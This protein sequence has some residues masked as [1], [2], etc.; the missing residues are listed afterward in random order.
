MTE[1][2]GPIVLDLLARAPLNE[3]GPGHPNLPARALLADLTPERLVAPDALSDRPMAL[4]ALAGLWLRHDFFDESH[5]I[6]QNLETPEGSYWHGI[7]HRREPDYGN[8]R[9]W[10]R[11]VAAH[12]IHK[13]LNA[14]AKTLCEGAEPMTSFARGEHSSS[15]PWDAAKF[16]QLCER[17]RGAGGAADR[18]PD[19]VAGMG[20]AV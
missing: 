2:Y 17:S 10:M 12:P 19:P 5:T 20:V 13:P 11:R 8:A 6:S 18:S 4:A 9:Y 3:L 15:D 16:V 14:Y 7:L 1:L